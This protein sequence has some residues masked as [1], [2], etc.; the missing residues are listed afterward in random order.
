[1]AS[2]ASPK[3]VRR[4][5][6]EQLLSTS[7]ARGR[8]SSVAPRVG[9][10]VVAVLADVAG[11]ER[12]ERLEPF[13]ELLRRHL[14][15]GLLLAQQPRRRLDRRRPR[16]L[17]GIGVVALRL[18]GGRRVDRVEVDVVEPVALLLVER[19][20]RATALVARGILADLRPEGGVLAPFAVAQDVARVARARL[21][22]LDALDRDVGL[23]A[24]GDTR[25]TD[26]VT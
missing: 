17:L 22:C 24:T 21:D 1:M 13:V 16:G 15:L 19:D 20:P 9:V 26:D 3:P 6:A 23:H 11:D 10:R 8:S 12:L 14:A 7:A 25:S 4:K 2:D 18:R 5:R